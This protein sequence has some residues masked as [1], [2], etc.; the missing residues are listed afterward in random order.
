MSQGLEVR[1][2]NYYVIEL[3]QLIG[4]KLD[5]KQMTKLQCGCFANKKRTRKDKRKTGIL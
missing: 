1:I 5:M 2:L 4:N 3:K